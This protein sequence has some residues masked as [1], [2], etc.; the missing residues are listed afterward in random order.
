MTQEQERCDHD[1]EYS[2]NWRD[3]IEFAALGEALEYPVRCTQC[4]LR[5]REIFIY[6]CCV[7]D[8]DVMV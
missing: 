2:E 8:D 1:W 7:T 5:A 3:E 4:G 6:A